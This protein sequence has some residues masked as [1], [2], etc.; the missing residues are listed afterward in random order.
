MNTPFY[1][2]LQ[3]KTYLDKI[4]K[5]IQQRLLKFI[6][7]KSF[8]PVLVVGSQISSSVSIVRPKSFGKYI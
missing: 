1:P 2:T 3:E 7:H 8:G 4:Q 5:L 6:L